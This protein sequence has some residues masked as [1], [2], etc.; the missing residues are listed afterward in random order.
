MNNKHS[1]SL[2][3]W[4]AVTPVAGKACCTICK[5][6]A[7]NCLRFDVG[8]FSSA[9]ICDGCLAVMLR[10]CDKKRSGEIKDGGE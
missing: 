7:E 4:E 9:T 1:N 6:N 5:G 2:S 3:V 8:L 10:M